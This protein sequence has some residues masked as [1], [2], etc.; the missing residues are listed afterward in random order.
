MTSPSGKAISQSTTRRACE[1]YRQL[2]A[3]YIRSELEPPTPRIAAYGGAVLDRYPEIDTEAGENSPRA[4]GPLMG[5]ASGPFLYS[6]WCTA[7]VTRHPPGLR[8]W[9]RAT[10]LFATTRRSVSS[11]PDHQGRARCV[12]DRPDHQGTLRVLTDRPRRRRTAAMLVA[13]LPALIPKL[14]VRPRRI[15]AHDVVVC[16]G[17]MRTAEIVIADHSQSVVHLPRLSRPWDLDLAYMRTCLDPQAVA[18]NTCPS[19]VSE[20]PRQTPAHPPR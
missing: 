20:R 13:A 18:S 15:R 8:N 12:P 3:R 7:S 14:T 2:H 1:E 4:T 10:A 19:Q 5:E 16:Y 9:P 6:R 17:R 11:G